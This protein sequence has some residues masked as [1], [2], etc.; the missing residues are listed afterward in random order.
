MSSY[1]LDTSAVVAHYRKEVG[2]AR[3]QA[4]FDDE[5]AV[6]W[7]AAPSLLE[8][9]TCLR[10]I[11]IE[12][13]VRRKTVNDYGGELV[14]IVPV[15]E[16]VVRRAMDLRDAAAG[17]LPA[18]DAL[19]AACAAVCGAVLV[20]RDSHFDAIPQEV[21]PSLRLSSQDDEAAT[22]AA[23]SDVVKEAKAAYKTGRTRSKVARTTDL[24]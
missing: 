5:D 21:L 22:A 4:L 2:H 1:L 17:R 12:A 18:M 10:D 3:V 6:L 16:R 11:G 9:D 14:H 23:A 8:L 15:D 7:F 24:H 20:H 13:T 19:I